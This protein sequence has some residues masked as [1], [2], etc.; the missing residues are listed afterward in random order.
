M[1]AQAK[2]PARPAPST[3]ITV[4][5]YDDGDADEV[6][7]RWHE[8]NVAAYPYVAEHQRHSLEDARRFFA[9]AVLTACRVFVAERDGARAGLIAIDGCWI[10]QLAVFAGHRRVGVGR[11]LLDVARTESPGEL[12]LH[13]FRRNAPARSFYEANGFSVT[14]FGTSP[15]PENEPDVEYHWAAARS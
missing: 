1:T 11:A 7:A 10:R 3:G 8:T 5:P 6:V 14:R 13:T 2:A 4:R 12:R 9:T 15:P